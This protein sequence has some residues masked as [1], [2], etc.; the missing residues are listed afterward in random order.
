MDQEVIYSGNDLGVHYTI[1]Y[2]RFRLWAPTADA[3]TLCLYKKGYGDCLLELLPME[4]DMGGTWVVSKDGD[5]NKT[6]YTYRVCRNGKTTETAD[7]YAR[8]AGVNGQRSMVINMQTVT[9]HGFYADM[10]PRPDRPTDIIICEISVADTTADSSS[11][12]LYA[13]KFLGLTERGTRN[14]AG[15]STG[16]DHLRELGV[17]HVQLMP[18]FDFASIDEEKMYTPQYNWGYDPLNYNVPE[19]SYATDPYHGEV[20]IREF[21]QMVQAIHDAG[22]GVIMDVVYNHTYDIEGSCFQKTEPDYYYRKDKKNY[23]DASACGN[24]IAS[25]RPMVHKYIVDSVCYWAKEYHIDGFRFDLMGVLDIDTLNDLSERLHDYNPYIILYGE[26][27]TGGSSVLP[28]Y[29]RAMK[30]NARMLHKIGMFSDDIRDTVKGHV[31]YEDI[32]GFVNGQQNLE[33][34]VRYAAA[35]GVWHPQVD[36]A[37]Y[38]YTAGGPW[39]ENPTDTVSYVS[40]HDNLTLWDKLTLSCPD[41]NKGKLLAMNRLAAAMIFTSQGIPFFLQGEEFARTKPIEGSDEVSENSY[42]LPLYTNSLKY[43]RLTKFQSLYEYYRGLIQFRKS[44]P[45]LR[46][47]TGAE[48]REG[49]HFIEGLHANVVAFTVDYKDNHVFVAYNANLRPVTVPLPEGKW[50]LQIDKEHAGTETLQ[51]VEEKVRLAGISCVALTV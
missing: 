25:E 9:P 26:G 31:F 7:P 38:A 28:E 3:V 45:A 18:V 23:S 33:N 16:L 11:G 4:R 10:G 17:T 20:R 46:L 48:V 42:N 49:L 36:Y 30:K 27:W 2:S 37:G 22:L 24:E 39:A 21:K 1:K 44:N 40:C 35:G 14:A 8:A 12:C 50:R 6:Y 51:L 15:L 29:R 19:G 41:A 34:S 32:R 43:N 13:G 5:L 47:A